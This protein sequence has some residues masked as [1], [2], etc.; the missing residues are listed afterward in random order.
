VFAIQIYVD[1]GFL[2]S[3][4]GNQRYHEQQFVS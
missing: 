3:L 2:A 1:P 4:L